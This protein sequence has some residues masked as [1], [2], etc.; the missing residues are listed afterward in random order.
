MKSRR[1]AF[2]SDGTESWPRSLWSAQRQGR[3]FPHI[4]NGSRHD[5]LIIG[6]GFTGLW[7]AL[8]LQRLDPSLVITVVDAVQPGFG[9]SGR[10]GGWCTATTPMSLGTLA[11]RHG[12]DAAR[13]MQSAMI[14]SVHEIGAFVRDEAIECGWTKSG[15]LTVARNHA[16][17]S[18]LDA[19]REEYAAHGFGDAID[20]LSRS[21]C[22]ER[23]KVNGA[24]GAAYFHHCATIQPLALVDGLVDV[25][26]RLGVRIHGRSPVVR[27]TPG[28]SGHRVEI[29]TPDGPATVSAGWVVRTTEGFTPLL[30][31]HRRHVAPLYSYM[32]ATEPLADSVWRE[33]GWNN[34]ETL[35]DGRTLV[36]YA[37]RT[38]DGRIAFGGRGAPYNFASRLSANFDDHP[39]IHRKVT[40][41]LRDL[42]PAAATAEITH[43]W[44]GALGVTRDWHSFVNVD[45]ATTTA[46][47]GG[48]AGDGVALAY[49]SGKCLASSVLG[50]SD[51][52]T[53]LPIVG[54]VSPPWE[55]EPLRWAGINAMLRTATLADRLESA[56]SPLA[57]PLKAIV[58][59][60][61][62]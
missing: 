59:R 57:R 46:S 7:T 51:H 14:D 26:T 53:S 4:E 30:A 50:R 37:Q 5:V 60:L 58:D 45:A 42:F 33:I 35:T 49:L 15:T 17:M 32:V 12:A 61:T 41:A 9:A 28:R 1:A 39:A 18:R 43:R 27:W 20:L 6:A 36:I 48:Y 23:V 10:N 55:P 44:G 2:G 21:E 8:H 11:D 47:A 16:Q 40:E 29:A 24:I 34:R 62:G 31:G 54:H 56:D 52:L 38:V 3:H 13:A 22:D 19:T 25:A